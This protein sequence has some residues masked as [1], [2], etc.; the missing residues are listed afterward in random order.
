MIQKIVEPQRLELRK[1]LGTIPTPEQLEL[2]WPK[3]LIA[4]S[5]ERAN[6]HPENPQTVMPD[7]FSHPHTRLG[8]E[9]TDWL[10]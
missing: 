5:L 1:R 7:G 6:L 10:V 9:V 8:T 2:G 3:S 4:T